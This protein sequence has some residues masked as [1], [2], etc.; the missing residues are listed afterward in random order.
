MQEINSSFKY[1][2]IHV[3]DNIGGWTWEGDPLIKVDHLIEPNCVV[4]QNV[5]QPFS[6]GVSLQFHGE[7]PLAT[8]ASAAVM[9]RGCGS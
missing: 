8:T 3:I 6:V 2:K 5:D 7:T 1:N 4:K 9:A